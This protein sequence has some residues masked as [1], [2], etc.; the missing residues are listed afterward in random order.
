[1]K[2]TSLHISFGI[3]ALCHLAGFGV[4]CWVAANHHR[5]ATLPEPEKA[6]TLTF[7]AAPA[8]P[9]SQPDKPVKPKPV[10]PPTQ[11][12]ISPAK[13]PAEIP[14][15]GEQP[16]PSVVVE[17]KPAPPR[18]PAQIRGD[19]SAPKPGVD[20]TTQRAEVGVKAVP[21]YLKNP[22]PPYP[23]A[24][25]RRHEEGVVLISVHVTA[26]GRAEKVEI[27]QSSGFP[28]LDE[29]A[30]NAVRDWE[31]VPARIGSITFASEI[32]VPIHFK[33]AQ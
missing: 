28:L 18:P 22:E 33:M 21:D 14:K 17:S 13:P 20:A 12:I 26:Q 30:L 1:M 23:A 27:K 2:L 10:V 32:E 25:R 29:A 19:G 6:I 7:I 3:S 24:A 11:Q 4:Y 15:I 16:K 31:F 5:L 8:A 9:A